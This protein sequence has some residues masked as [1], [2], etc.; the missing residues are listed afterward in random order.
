[1]SDTSF[2]YAADRC[3][4]QSAR[5]HTFAADDARPD[6]LHAALAVRHRRG[7]VRSIDTGAAEPWAASAWS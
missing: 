3:T 4:R 7:R 6:M 1:M 5:R 2:L